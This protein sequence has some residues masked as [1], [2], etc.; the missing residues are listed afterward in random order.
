MAVVLLA[1]GACQ[2]PQKRGDAEAVRAQELAVV[3]SL[4]VQ[5]VSQLKTGQWVLYTVRTAGSPT[6]LSTRIAVVA[7]EGD[8]FWIENRSDQESGRI[9]SKIQ[10]DKT[11]RLL[12]LWVGEFGTNHPAKVYPG[13]DASGNPMEPP[14]THYPDAKSKVEITKERITISTTGKAYD[15]TRLTS[16]ATYPDGRETTLVTWCSPEV[17]FGVAYEGKSYG[18][19][20]RRTYGRHTMELT[21][22]GTDALPELAL[23][24]K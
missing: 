4:S 19:V 10:V 2:P 6:P 1:L 16:M 18:G 5:E 15:C 3:M 22:R 24:E 23:P 8:R 12:Q 20:V 17:P 14:K 21:A 7:A 13:K 9:I 11:G